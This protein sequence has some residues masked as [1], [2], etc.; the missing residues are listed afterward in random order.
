M[1]FSLRVKA[2]KIIRNL[3]LFRS[4]LTGIFKSLRFRRV[5]ILDVGKRALLLVPDVPDLSC[6]VK[7]AVNDKPTKQEDRR[8]RTRQ[9]IL[10][11]VDCGK[12]CA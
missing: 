2:S 6:V 9:I 3:D 11:V 1:T 8:K 4:F 10:L 7:Q 12:T 5:E